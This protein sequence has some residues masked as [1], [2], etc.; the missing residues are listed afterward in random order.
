MQTVE[1]WRSTPNVLVDLVWGW[2]LA[3]RSS[4]RDALLWLV[5]SILSGIAPMA[6]LLVARF[7]LRG[8]N[9]QPQIASQAPDLLP[10]IGLVLLAASLGYLLLALAKSLHTRL[11]IQ[12]RDA[13]MALF[14]HKVNGLP[15]AFFDNGR[16]QNL[17][18]RA[19]V[20]V[21]EQPA[22]I[23]DASGSFLRT[24]LFFLAILLYLGSLSWVY[25]LVLTVA[26][27]PAIAAYLYAT[28]K[29][30][31]IRQR[32]TVL[33]RMASHLLFML[34]DGR[35]IQEL[36]LTRA[37]R[38]FTAQRAGLQDKLNHG[39]RSRARIDL[40]T[41]L[42]A[43]AGLLLSIG[44]G[45]A[46]MVLQYSSGEMDIAEL[47]VGFYAFLIAHRMA[48]SAL[49]AA[50]TLYRGGLYLGDLREILN[51]AVSADGRPAKQFSTQACQQLQTLQQGIAL[52]N[53]SF[54]YP[55]AQS[56]ALSNINLEF[57]ANQVTVLVGANGCG[58]ST[59]LRLI[60]GLYAPDSGN[61][62]IDGQ[63]LAEIDPE[64]WRDGVALMF[65][66]YARFPG[67]L[68]QNVQ[69]ER[70]PAAQNWQLSREFGQLDPLLAQ[71]PQA[72]NTRL[73]K[74]FGGT[75]LSGG[76]WQRV[77]LARAIATDAPVLLLDEPTSSLDPAARNLFWE[78]LARFGK[79]RITIVASHDAPYF[80]NKGFVHHDMSS[81]VIT[82]DP[83]SDPH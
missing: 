12:V 33:R 14:L 49:E 32:E 74:H 55:G 48:G 53:I 5:V 64:T 68:R 46:W 59:L 28:V 51:I 40:V 23:F 61:I 72:E 7:A 8:M 79:N 10:L 41:Q 3:F 67:S 36:R 15:P 54:R 81:F 45:L 25:P 17:L 77:A 26:A 69:L 44:I 66:E 76:Q 34:T 4:P 50:T 20:S 31:R 52:E 30:H 24:G 83:T 42:V 18:H 47:A 70:K 39:E 13:S 65:Q 43:G 16:N 56:A 38:A 35:V 58:K 82:A 22:A 62:R 6:L 71:L 63:P 11:S 60:A 75:E 57:A 19:R 9:D 2:A 37:D 1:L 29:T 78:N 21:A 80:R 73:K 27:L